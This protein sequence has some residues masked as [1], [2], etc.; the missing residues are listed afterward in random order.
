[1]HDNELQ[2]FRLSEQKNTVS[3][4]T[5]TKIQNILAIIILEKNVIFAPVILLTVNFVLIVA[6]GVSL[7]A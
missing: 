6:A 1:M 3:I 5:W 4:K 7:V 2:R